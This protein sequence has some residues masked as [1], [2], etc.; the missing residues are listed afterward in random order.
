[1]EYASPETIAKIRSELESMQDRFIRYDPSLH[2]S[3]R[4]A[5]FHAAIAAEI[6]IVEELLEYID[7]GMEPIKFLERSLQFCAN[8]RSH[9]EA[10]KLRASYT[11]EI[12][13]LYWEDTENDT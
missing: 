9:P 10:V 6:N 8:D 5:R 2:K 7:Q 3:L 4:D 1:M 13:D 11:L 12:L